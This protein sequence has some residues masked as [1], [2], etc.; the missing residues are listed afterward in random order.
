ME[1]MATD[2]PVAVFFGHSDAPKFSQYDARRR[3][4]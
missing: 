3:I 2:A 1:Q 4:K